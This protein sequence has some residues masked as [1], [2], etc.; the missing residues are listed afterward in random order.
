[1]KTTL[2][3]TILLIL[4]FGCGEFQEKFSLIMKINKDLRKNFNHEN[5]NIGFGM[6]TEQSDNHLAVT[7]AYFPIDSVG[8]ETFEEMATMVSDLLYEKYPEMSEMSYVE[9]IF[10]NGAGIQNGESFY[11]YKRENE[12]KLEEE[13]MKKI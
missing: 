4:L 5:I 6:G 10:S 13:E 11:Q 7:F 1:M 12:T 9:I 2:I 3:G 8:A